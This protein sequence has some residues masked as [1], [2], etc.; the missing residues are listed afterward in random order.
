MN[1][2]LGLR[3]LALL[4]FVAVSTALIVMPQ[5]LGGDLQIFHSGVALSHS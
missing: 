2:A 3:A 4:A 1:I 5:L